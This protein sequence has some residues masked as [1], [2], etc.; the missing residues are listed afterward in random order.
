M[1]GIKSK[2][3]EV[4]NHWIGFIEGFSFSPQEFYTTFEKHLTLRRVPGLETARIELGEGG[5]LSDRRLYVRLLREHLAFDICA[6]PFGTSY[7]FSCRTV[8][9]P[10]AVQLW[11]LLVVLLFFLIVFVGLAGPLGITYAA[12]AAV[13]LPFAIIQVLRNTW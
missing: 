1:L 3:G 5:F 4:L 11:H 2:R 10:V 9:M 7:F 6:A 8:E 12:I 13:T